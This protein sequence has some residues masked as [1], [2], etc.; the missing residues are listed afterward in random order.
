MS[1]LTELGQAKVLDR[2]ETL[3]NRQQ[4]A[5]AHWSGS[6]LYGHRTNVEARHEM[7]RIQKRIDR[8]KR[9]LR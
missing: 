3:Q 7:E 8:L 4:L 6:V 5:Y 9:L 2:I 1:N